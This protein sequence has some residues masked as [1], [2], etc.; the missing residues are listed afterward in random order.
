MPRTRA[1]RTAGHPPP[2]RFLQATAIVATVGV[3]VALLG[4]VALLRPVS[5]PVQDCG[6]AIG[7]LLDGRTNTFADP[8]DPPEGL[9]AEEVTAN[10]E[11]PC[12]ERVADAA[13]PGGI[14][15]VVGLLLA[16]VAFLVEAVARFG[17]WLARRQ[18][19]RARSRPTEPADDLHGGG[20]RSTPPG[21]PLPGEAEGSEPSDAEPA[22]A[23]A[24]DAGGS[25]AGDA[26]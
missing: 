11:R 6:T 2:T 14:A 1:D 18:Q 4:L 22:D 26:G 9:T 5:T 17:S 20:A 10:N 3:V 23:G 25:A 19:A 21:D 8:A 12:R 16:V 13:R 24:L 7:F 15:F